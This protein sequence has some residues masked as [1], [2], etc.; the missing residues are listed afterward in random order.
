MKKIRRD[1]IVGKHLHCKIKYA[2]TFIMAV[3]FTVSFVK[4]S[5][6]ELTYN[7]QWRIMHSP[8]DTLV[9]YCYSMFA[10]LCCVA[11]MLKNNN[12]I[13]CIWRSERI[14]WSELHRQ[15]VTGTLTEVDGLV[16][17]VQHGLR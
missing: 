1:V 16:T 2:K 6:L 3:S 12:I 10:Y 4:T 17:C 11:I 9:T 14:V 15:N 7:P 8:C 13:I 5:R